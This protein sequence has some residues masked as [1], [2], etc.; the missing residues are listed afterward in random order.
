MVANDMADTEMK[1]GLPSREMR[2]AS[3]PPV[4]ASTTPTLR[5]QT[6]LKRAMFN[7]NFNFISIH[8]FQLFNVAHLRCFPYRT[9]TPSYA[10]EEKLLDAIHR[11]DAR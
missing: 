1:M 8:S 2:F 11:Y 6:S 10:N 9:R 5:E 7:F 4:D 3:G